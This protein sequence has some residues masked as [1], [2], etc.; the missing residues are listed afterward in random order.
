MK[1]TLLT[2]HIIAF[3]KKYFLHTKNER[4]SYPDWQDLSLSLHTHT[5]TNQ[6]PG[7]ITQSKQ[8]KSN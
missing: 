6:G 5:H 8:Q 3:F 1:L 4:V 2:L 7:G